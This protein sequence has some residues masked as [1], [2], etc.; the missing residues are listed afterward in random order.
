M[1]R[2]QTRAAGE[3]EDPA[4]IAPAARH[5][6]ERQKGLSGDFRD[7]SGKTSNEQ[8]AAFLRQ[9]AGVS[10][11]AHERVI[12]PDTGGETIAVQ[13]E[14]IEAIAAAMEG[15]RGSGGSGSSAGQSSG[16]AMG[17]G[18][19]ISGGGSL[20]GGDTA[21]VGR[22]GGPGSADIEGRESAR[23]SRPDV[24]TWPTEYRDAIQ[25]YYEALEGR[26]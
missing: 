24:S 3:T 1:L 9:L 17:T 20:A 19:G 16:T 25:A 21:G 8:V 6:G 18:A 12:R 23:A 14:I 7:L 4:D 26:P 10:D 15:Q 11:E 22:H 2:E 13:T 5:I